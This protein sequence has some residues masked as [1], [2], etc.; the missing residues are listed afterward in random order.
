MQSIAHK[1]FNP[2]ILHEDVMKN[3][4]AGKKILVMGVANERSI[5]WGIAK[6]CHEQGAELG[7]TYQGEALKK[8]IMPLAESIG[9]SLILECDVTDD[10]ALSTTFNQIEEKWGKF[11][12]IV[13]SIAFS[14][15]E[16][17]KGKYLATSRENFLKSMDIS[18][19]SL[20]K[21]CQLSENLLNDGASIITLTYYGAEQVLPHYNVMGVAKAALEA[22]VRYLANDL[23]PQA[24]SLNTFSGRVYKKVLVIEFQQ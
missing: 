21:I 8:R 16:E 6:A 7:F 5:A 20:T 17:L 19:Y 23:G 4:M 10:E 12:G 1:I 14:D 2:K 18:C 22:S 11:D 9:A 13:H 24:M 15:K 3:L